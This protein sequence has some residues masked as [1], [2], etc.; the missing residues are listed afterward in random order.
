MDGA[1][2]TCGLG[3]LS[4]LFTRTYFHVEDALLGAYNILCYGAPKI[5]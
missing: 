2:V 5:W 3:I 1:G 4:T